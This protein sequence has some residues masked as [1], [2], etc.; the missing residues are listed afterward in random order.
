MHVLEEMIARQSAG[1]IDTFDRAAEEALEI[2]PFDVIHDTALKIILLLVCGDEL[3][4]NDATFLNSKEYE[5]LAWTLYAD[6]SLDATLVDTFPWLIHAPLRFSK[7][8]EERK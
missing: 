6:T 1:M 2:D 3:S 5:A 4:N 8:F 7:F